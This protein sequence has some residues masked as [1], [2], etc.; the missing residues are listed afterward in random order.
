MCRLG[1]VAQVDKIRSHTLRSLLGLLQNRRLPMCPSCLALL[2]RLRGSYLLGQACWTSS[3]L[4][5]HVAQAGLMGHGQLAPCPRR[6]LQAL[7]K[8]AQFTPQNPTNLLQG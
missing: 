4:R 6:S 2:S 1:E 5:G 8:L 7:P 3:T